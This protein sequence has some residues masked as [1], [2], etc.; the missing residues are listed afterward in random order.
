MVAIGVIAAAIVVGLSIAGLSFVLERAA[1]LVAA[2]T[3]AL[4]FAAQNTVTSRRS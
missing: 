2:L 3:V 1:I 4:G